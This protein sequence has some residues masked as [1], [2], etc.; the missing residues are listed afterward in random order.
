MISTDEIV[1]PYLTDLNDIDWDEH[2]KST[3]THSA[4]LRLFMKWAYKVEK[5]WY[6]FALGEIPTTWTMVIDK[7]LEELDKVAP[8]FKI[9]QIKLKFGGLRFYVELNVDDAALVT[10]INDQIGQLEQRL[11]NDALIY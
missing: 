2:L 9:H 5:G 8:N 7:F 1:R 6:G 4:D 10:A 3:D 11:C